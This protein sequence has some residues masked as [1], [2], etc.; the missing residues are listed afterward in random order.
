MDF[1]KACLTCIGHHIQIYITVNMYVQKE[2]NKTTYPHLFYHAI[3]HST[4]RCDFTYHTEGLDYYGR[5]IRN[6]TF[7]TLFLPRRDRRAF[8]VTHDRCHHGGS[9]NL[10]E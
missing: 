4:V 10:S 2:I 7:F 9:G 8:R 6:R 1:F 5:L 3:L